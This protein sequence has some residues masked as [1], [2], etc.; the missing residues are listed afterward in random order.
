MKNIGFISYRRYIIGH[1]SELTEH[2]QI[3][4][5]HP[6]HPAEQSAPHGHSKISGSW[7]RESELVFFRAQLRIC[8]I[9]NIQYLRFTQSTSALRQ[10]ATH[11]ESVGSQFVM[12]ARVSWTQTSLQTPLSSKSLENITW[13]YIDWNLTVLTDNLDPLYGPFG[14]QRPGPVKIKRRLSFWIFDISIRFY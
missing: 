10:V 11:S 8:R 6:W 9:K 3:G 14:E 5:S 2:W 4:L 12:H 13:P 1:E 7:L